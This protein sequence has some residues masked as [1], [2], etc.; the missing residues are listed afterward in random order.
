LI[1]DTDV[2]VD[3][4]WDAA[5]SLGSIVRVDFSGPDK[6]EKAEKWLVGTN[7]GRMLE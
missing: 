3:T 5:D 6:L 4:R 2:D 1:L 7:G